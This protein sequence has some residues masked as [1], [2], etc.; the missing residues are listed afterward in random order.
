MRRDGK[1]GQKG[2]FS[3]PE[4]LPAIPERDPGSGLGAR[5]IPPGLPRVDR[6]CEI[7]N[8]LKEETTARS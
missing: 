5:E 7:D 2:S 6:T 3:L 4:I 8:S 1:R